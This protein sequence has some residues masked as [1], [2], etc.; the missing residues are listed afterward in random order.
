MKKKAS[1]ILL[2]VAVL[3]LCVSITS[4]AHAFFFTTSSVG[5]PDRPAFGV[6]D[7]GSG[8]VSVS[9][10]VELVAQSKDTS[11]SGAGTLDGPSATNRI[12]LK[13]ANDLILTGDLIITADCH[14]NLNGF[15]LNLNGHTV[16]VSHNYEG[17]FV[18][19]GGTLRVKTREDAVY[20]NTP[21]AVVK[22]EVAVYREGIEEPQE[23]SDYV[24]ILGA[25]ENW[26]AYN[27]FFDISQRLAD[28][29]DNSVRRLTYAEIK[30][31]FEEDLD[32]DGQPDNVDFG[33]VHFLP[34]HAG[35]TGGE[36]LRCA[37]VYQDLDLPASYYGY[38]VEIEYWSDS[39]ALSASGKVTTSQSAQTA[40]LTVTLRNGEGE[41][42]ASKAFTV[43][44]IGAANGGA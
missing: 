31:H 27:I 25:D 36:P 16:T 28:P 23:L 39:G 30:K 35:V 19:G 43:L 33:N 3:Q 12:T 38:G 10:E 37:Y 9:T 5:D 21:N 32:G 18:I 26:L 1:V 42:F 40:V 6:N 29:K 4:F 22:T 11:G 20:I 24:K 15:A 7:D 8:T 41:I 17:T 34:E 44:V 2:I 14:I 13:L